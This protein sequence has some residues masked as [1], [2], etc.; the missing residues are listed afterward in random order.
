MRKRI[1][2]L[3]L[4]ALLAGCTDSPLFNKQKA[5][6][7]NDATGPYINL[8]TYVFSTVVGKPIDFSN[9]T[10]YDDVDG[11]MP[12]SLSGYVNYSQAGEYYPSLVCTDTSGN[13]TSQVITIT[14]LEENVPTPPSDAQETEAPVLAAPEPQTCEEAGAEDKNY[15]CSTVLPSA[16]IDYIAIYESEE[17]KEACEMQ[18][19]VQNEDG[20]QAVCETIVRNNGQFWGY[21]LKDE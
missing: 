3:L 10:G 20:G 9:I 11:M 16:I 19:E 12:V 8:S 15:A 5:V 17:G 14:V 1:T 2:A 4:A 7:S 18:A 13:T 21:G 6:Q